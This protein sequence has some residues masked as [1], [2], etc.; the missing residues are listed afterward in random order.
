[1]PAPRNR[2]HLLVQTA[3]TVEPY[4]PHPRKIEPAT[5]AGPQD[6]N[7]H[8]AALRNA[9]S[10]ARHEAEDARAATGIFVHGAEPGLYVEFE[11]PPNED[12]KLESLEHRGRSIETVAVR[13]V[14]RESD[15]SSV[16]LAT[17][18]VPDG[19]LNH[20][21]DHF[22]QYAEATTA[23]GQ[24]RHKD[25]VDRIAVLRRATLRA[26]WTDATEIYPDELDTIWWEVWL[27]RHD[28]KELQRLFEFADQSELAI[29]E[30]RI[31]F[32]D[33]I[34][35][36]VKGTATQLSASLAVLNDLAEV[37][38]AKEGS[39]FFVDLPLQ[40]QA[41]WLDDLTERVAQPIADPPAVCLLDTGITQ[42][43]PLLRNLID[44][45]DALS[46]DPAWGSH[47]NG[48]GS[49]NRGHGTEM[50]GLAAY[51]DL[52]AVLASAG[53]VAVPHRLESVKI[54]PPTGE[55]R[56]EL[57]GAITAQAV[58]R[59]EVNN[60]RR[61][62]VFSMAVTATD[63]RDCGQPTSWSAA[64]D[65]LAVGHI[66]DPTTQGL[67]YLDEADEVA[68]RLFVLRET[69]P[70]TIC[71]LTTSIVVMWSPYTIQLMPGM[72]LQ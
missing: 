19:A 45:A 52:A 6:R 36:L 68:R 4:S 7:R 38:K 71:R 51:G 26:L 34:V 12:L 62:R 11:S 24:P 46:V 23:T 55:N 57:Y 63:N 61:R 17:V 33:R 21:F 59:P 65:A 54:L 60:P 13:S 5:F 1:M 50:A 16:Q 32:E 15:D 43:H 40:E 31:G 27:R 25:M 10:A 30:R 53:P 28:G 29:S 69:W 22:R 44:P 72:L 2:K 41:E 49:A 70:Q 18:F 3:P 47:D 20:F 14:K 56:P 58:A 64:I 42:G 35:I 39:A 67:V 37:R 8:A 66:F 48:G 9:L